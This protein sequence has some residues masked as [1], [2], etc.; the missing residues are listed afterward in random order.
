M[1][2]DLETITVQRDGH[3]VL[4]TIDHPKSAMNAVDELLHRELAELFRYLAVGEDELIVGA[5]VIVIT[6][7][8]PAFSSGGD[9]SWFP[10]LNSPDRLNRLRREGKQIIWDLLDIEPPIIC[11]LNGP[12]VGLGASIALMCDLIVMADTATLIDPHVKVGLVAGDGGA[13]IWPLLVGP[14]AAKR[15]LMLGL[16]LGADEALRLGI[17]V[18]VCDRADVVTSARQWADDL[19]AQPP[20][21][22]QGTKIS[23]NQQ[24]K[25]ALLSSFDVSMALEMTCFHTDDHAEAVAA[26]V[27]K[28]AARYTGS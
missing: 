10:Q 21:A 25:Q 5:R 17:A 1:G 7:H 14:L 26:F 2:V 3:V 16:P 19:A 12:A 27:D 4:V 13:A 23:I 22:V 18:E 20:L 11:A 24:I 9:M 6:G 28:R 8:G 15:H